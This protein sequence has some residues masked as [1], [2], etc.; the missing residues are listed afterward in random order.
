MMMHIMTESG[1]DFYN[2][3]IAIIYDGGSIQ[4][5]IHLDRNVTDPQCYR[6]L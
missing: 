1:G 2:E 4:L 3:P 6:L 5:P